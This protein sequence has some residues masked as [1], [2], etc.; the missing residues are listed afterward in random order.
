MT[1]AEWDAMCQENRDT[2]V[3]EK[4][5]KW[6][7]RYVT[8]D[9]MKESFYNWVDEKNVGQDRPDE[10]CPTTDRNACAFVLDEIKRRR[11]LADFLIQIAIEL[12][13]PSNGDEMTYIYSGL[14]ADPDTIC[15]C[16]VKAVEDGH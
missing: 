15:Y 1:K 3:A 12:K 16:A 14:S 8:D 5:M 6:R 7:L 9:I 4:V 10:F 11:D 2:L 13:L